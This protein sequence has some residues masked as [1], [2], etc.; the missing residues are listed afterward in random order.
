MSTS[1]FEAIAP[2]APAPHPVTLPRVAQAPVL[3][4]PLAVTDYERTL[5][6]IDAAIA[7]GAREY[8]CVAAVHTVMECARRRRRC[9][10]RSTA[11]PSRCPTASRSRGRCASSATTSTRASTAP[12]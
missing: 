1:S 10:R 7:L 8:L 9:A 12:S 11:P 5:D 4:T 3:G 2:A 6:W